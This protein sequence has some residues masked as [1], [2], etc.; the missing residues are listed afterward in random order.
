MYCFIFCCVAFQ[1][2]GNDPQTV[3][4]A[5]RLCENQCDG[6]DLNLGCPQ[7]IARRGHYG[8]FLQEEWDLIER[9][10]MTSSSRFR[11]ILNNYDMLVTIVIIMENVTKSIN[12]N[13]VFCFTRCSY[14][15]FKGAKSAVYC[16]NSGFSRS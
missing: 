8:A 4:T 13:T 3:L 15:V 7:G 5:C 2:C 16:K 1:F 6:I 12:L 9:I 14:A 10:G 11:H